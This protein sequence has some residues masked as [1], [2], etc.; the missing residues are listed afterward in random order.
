MQR[1]NAESASRVD[2]SHFVAPCR[3]QLERIACVRRNN[4]SNDVKMDISR[5]VKLKFSEVTLQANVLAIFKG[6]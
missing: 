3:E 1:G 2:V 6:K 5:P 4:I